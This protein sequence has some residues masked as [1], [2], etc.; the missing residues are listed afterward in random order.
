M[1][2]K[3][4]ERN[5]MYLLGNEWLKSNTLGPFDTMLIF[6]EFSD[7]PDKNLKDAINTID[8]GGFVELSSNY[9]NISLTQKGLSKIKVL[10]QPQNGEL[11]VPTELE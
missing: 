4:I 10:K 7:I 5:I 1:E 3:N 8:E 2:I 9:R 6:D 11:P